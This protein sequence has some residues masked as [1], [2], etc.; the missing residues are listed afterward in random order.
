MNNIHLLGSIVNDLENELM[1]YAKTAKASDY[2]IKQRQKL[3][4]QLSGV[5]DGYKD[6]TMWEAFRAVNEDINKL[7]ERDKELSHVIIVFPLLP[8]K[9]DA[10]HCGFIDYSERDDVVIKSKPDT[11]LD[12]GYYNK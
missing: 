5:Y 12:E 4:D 8:V 2:I 7:M 6:F 3:I 1:K 9:F 11:Y 10:S